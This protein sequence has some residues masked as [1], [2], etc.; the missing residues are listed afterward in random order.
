MASASEFDL[1]GR[2]LAGRGASRDDVL[3]GVGDDAAVLAGDQR[4]LLVALDTL[5]EG[6][7]FPADLPAAWVGYRALA[8]NLS[9]IAAMGGEP[10]WALL[11]LT[12]PEADEAWVAAFADGLDGLAR[13]HSVALAGGDVTRGPLSISVQIAGH[14][15]GP[16]LRRDGA[17]IGDRLWVSGRPGEAMAGLAAWQDPATRHQPQWQGLQRAFVAPRP[18]VALGRA[19]VG[20][21]SAAID[22]SDGLVADAGHIARR[23]GVA[24]ALRAADCTGSARLHRW[25]GEAAARRWMLAGGDDYELC[26]TAPPAADAAVRAAA[27]ASRTP[28][29]AI[30]RVQAGEGVWLDGESLTGKACGYRHFTR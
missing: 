4:P 21:A 5:V 3:L 27:R 1:I 25:Q 30:G 28:V 7:H 29:R 15:N 18:R 17:A 23:S 10:C 24:I 16:V 6:V 14:A 22:V 20:I 13:R 19:L 2:Y 26:F 8:V 9:D 12:L 11:G